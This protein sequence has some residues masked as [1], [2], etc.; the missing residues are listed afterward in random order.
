MSLKTKATLF[1]IAISVLP[2]LATGVFLFQNN[3]RALEDKLV[4]AQETNA[5]ILADGLSHFLFERY[6]DIRILADFP[7]L[8]DNRLIQETSLGQRQASLNRF[9]QSSGV[10]DN[11]SVTD[12]DGRVTL[13]AGILAETNLSGMDYFK[14]ALKTRQPV[15]SSPRRVTN[16]GVYS[17]AIAAPIFDTATGALM[18]VVSARVPVSKLEDFFIK[19]NPDLV[20]SGEYHFLDQNLVIFGAGEQQ[21]IGKAAPNLFKGFTQLVNGYRLQTKVLNA[22]DDQE[23]VASY[24]PVHPIGGTPDVQWGVMLR[25]EVEALRDAQLRRWLIAIGIMSGIALLVAALAALVARRIATPISRASNAIHDLSEGKF[26]TRL[27][28]RGSDEFAQ[29]GKNFNGLAEQFQT[30]SQGQKSLLDRTELLKT[31]ALHMSEVL[32]PTEKLKVAMDDL[33]LAMKLDRVFM[34][35][36]DQHQAGTIVCESVSPGWS[37]LEG[38][39]G[40]DYCFAEQFLEQYKQERVLA[41]SDIQESELTQNSIDQLEPLGVRA[42]LVAPMFANRQLLGVLIAHQCSD[43]RVWQPDEIELFAQSADAL[44]VVWD[45]TTD[46]MQTLLGQVEQSALQ[47]RAFVQKDESTLRQV[48][49]GTSRLTEEIAEALKSLNWV[50]ASLQAITNQASQVEAISHTMADTASLGKTAVE[51]TGHT[52]LSIR[53]TVAQVLKKANL[54]GESSQHIASIVKQVQQIVTQMNV[55]AV[56]ANLEAAR[57]GEAGEGLSDVV[58]QVSDLSTRSAIAIQELEALAHHVQQEA[59]DVIGMLD[60]SSTQVVEGSQLFEETQQSLVQMMTVSQSIEE[61]VHSIASE[62]DSQTQVTYDINHVI[63]KLA[64]ETDQTADQSHQVLKS[65]QDALSALHRLQNTIDLTKVDS[66]PEP[67]TIKGSL[68][69]Y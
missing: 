62:T 68:P 57:A 38:L 66:A 17:F 25:Q 14:E 65:L 53:Q 64:R 45:R 10:F 9:I 5:L 51:R 11:I 18:G 1:A 60:M 47:A 4:K 69:G 24:A 48:T 22:G 3:D 63:E 40:N 33:R 31:M 35:R 46:N 36:C 61:L 8:N 16:T 52:M 50:A 27:A 23:N 43:S 34:V 20:R 6:G 39:H 49:E 21:D 67:V 56:N 28:V 59:H 15:I 29:L 37:R 55:L 32:K 19:N 42:K 26:E 13:Q 2:V 7:L 58:A 54:L 30:I 44:S 41:I 12:L